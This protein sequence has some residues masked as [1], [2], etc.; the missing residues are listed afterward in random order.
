MKIKNISCTQFA[1]IGE[2]DISF[3]DGVNV[4][5]GKNESGKST[6]VNLL[7]R[8]LFQNARIDG[9]KDKD[10]K[11]LYFPGARKGSKIKGDFIDG[12]V[13]IETESGT[14]KLE[15]EWGGDSV[16]K[17]HTPDGVISDQDNID[18]ILRELLIYGEGVYN[19][20]LFSSQRN[21]DVS[22]QT[23]LDVSKSSDAKQEIID[24]VS[25]A[26]AESDGISVD[27]IEQEINAKIEEIAGKH[28]D[29]RRKKPDRRSDDKEWSRDRGEILNAYY[30]LKKAEKAL[31]NIS[32]LKSEAYDAAAEYKKKDNDYRTAEEKYEKFNKYASRLTTWNERQKNIQYIEGEVRE[33]TNALENWPKFEENIKQAEALQSEK[34]NRKILDKYR[35]AKTINDRIAEFNSSIENLICPT[36]DEIKQVKRSENKLNQLEN[37]LCGMNLTAAVNMLGNNSVEI[38]SLRTGE[39]VDISG[40]IASINEAVK[41]TVPGVM[42]MQLSPT[43]VDV[44]SI[45][46]QISEQKR[47]IDGIF[48]KH[49]VDSLGKLEEIRE[50][51]RKVNGYIE[52]EENNLDQL[53]GSESFEELKSKA[54][55]VTEAVRSEEE[56]D[57]DIYNLCLF[58]DISTFIT[59]KKQRVDDYTANYGSIDD[60][61][62]KADDSRRQLKKKRKE[63]DGAEGI[64]EEYLNIS[65]PDDYLEELQNDR[66]EKREKREE[67]FT[68]KT[69]AE[70]N[71]N[72]GNENMDI[73]DAKEKVEQAQRIFDETQSLLSH[74]QHIKEVFDKQK[75]MINT[76][77]MQDIADRLA[78]YL[79]IISESKISSEFPEANRLDMNIYSD[80]RLLDYSKL[81]EG[82]KETVSLAFR[83][84]VLDHLFPEGGGVIVF[85]DPL[86][87]MDADRAAQS[88]E[89]I[90]ECAK[91]HQVIFLTC[92]EEYFDMLSGN[93]IRL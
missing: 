63:V 44:A 23:I 91:R 87:D 31:D 73:D 14:Y 16:C 32:K 64:P 54:D 61:K 19:D 83:L 92:R 37:Q 2:R 67:A 5:Y 59:K 36:D 28:W 86:T 34:E 40:G 30:G 62:L 79:G 48:E 21:T 90:K 76:N 75:E 81:S 70:S 39:A 41:I 82:T 84:A 46:E 13:I 22:L 4:I 7:S 6:M 52:R 17:L 69:Q 10:F 9:R 74:W 60:L 25:Q 8:T 45:E 93:E 78:E 68:R 18:E 43:D 24:V 50:S 53:R 15:K 11:G 77:P 51:I 33:M 65:D 71:F 88:C 55:A 35:E 20:I 27:L 12:K 49:K 1:G 26:F 66:D 80:N 42:E 29:S 57:N 47:I 38:T 72:N 58:D 3:T 56:I 85:D 89:L